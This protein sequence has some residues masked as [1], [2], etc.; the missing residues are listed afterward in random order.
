M[1]ART[2]IK[3]NFRIR[4]RDFVNLVISNKADAITR[5]YYLRFTDSD[6]PF[7]IFKLFY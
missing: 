1:A 3:K 6:Y 2:D 7:G 4:I 5:E